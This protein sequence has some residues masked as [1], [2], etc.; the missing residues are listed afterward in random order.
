MMAC[1]DDDFMIISGN[2]NRPLAEK[3][4][5]YLGMQLADVEI[6]KFAN[7]NTFVHIKENVRKRDLFIIQPTCRPTN[8]NLMELLITID[9]AKRASA[10]S[11]TAVIPYFDYAR[12]DKKDQPRVPITAK[13]V[14]DMITMAGATRVITMDLHAEQIQGFFTIPV[15]HLYAA[16]V[17]I[18]YLKKLDLGE[19]V[20]VAPDAGGALRARGIA[21]RI[22]ASLAIID[23]RRTGNLDT[24]EVY[25]VVGDVEGKHCVLVDDIVDTGGTL[26]KA[27]KAI[28]DAGAQDVY[29]AIT[30]AVFSRD[31][32]KK[33][34]ESVL[35]Q[36]IVTDT[37]PIT[38]E[39]QNDKI[40]VLSVAPLLGETIRRVQMGESVSSLFL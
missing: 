5:S 8:D 16:P 28:K 36:L 4:C 7:D 33:I 38:F 10:R 6:F 22:P 25:H 17:V 9:A 39:K 35:E 20:I 14:A 1:D 34:S 27:A 40:K 19:F 24:I 13:L 29:A 23:K 18:D 30:H 2:A 21:K 32:V 31:A 26:L 15:D 37:I 11:I 12:S 3:I